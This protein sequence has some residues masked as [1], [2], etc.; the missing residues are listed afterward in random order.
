MTVYHI[1]PVCVG[2]APTVVDTV[3]ALVDMTLTSVGV[4]AAKNDLK[5]ERWPIH[6]KL[7]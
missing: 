3:F 5:K 4:E 1:V 2:I 7:E 6:Y